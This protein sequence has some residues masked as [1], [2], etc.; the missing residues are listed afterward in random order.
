MKPRVSDFNRRGERG[1]A[2]ITAL[3]VSTLLLTMGGALILTT[4][5]ASGLAIDSTTELQAYYAAE[6]GV[7]TALNILR[8]NIESNPAG[9]R[10]TF[11]NAAD[12]PTLNN[13]VTYDAVYD[14]DNVVQISNTPAMAYSITVT[15]LDNTIAPDEPSRLKVHVEGYGPNGAK[16]HMEVVV[17]RFIFDFSPLATILMRGNDDGTTGMPTFAIGESNAKEYSGYD[18]ADPTT[19]LPVFGVTHGTDLT[20]ATTTVADSKPDTVS[21]VDEVTQF[22]NQDLPYFLQ[23]AD[24][25]RA[26]LNTLQEQAVTN[27]RYF[28]SAPADFGSAANPK[29]TFIDGDATLV[30]GA[31]LLV[32][33]G[34][35]SSDGNVGFKGIILVMGKGVYERS[36]TG[37]AD[38]LGAIVIASFARTWPSSENNDPHPFLSPVFN[39]TGGGTGTTGYDSAEVTRA[40]ATNGL[41]SLGVREY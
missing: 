5:L 1:A 12:N 18:N 3:M 22:A 35:L 14:G 20:G 7:N 2:L 27:N 23:T 13:W 41:R 38:T 17:S 29:F 24:N 10:A 31:G 16:K 33:T 11:R 25:A 8:G 32:V 34:T 28:T 15:D 9:T 37:N 21:G 36:G 30:E 19:S 6:A 26:F 40:L 4:N 39:T